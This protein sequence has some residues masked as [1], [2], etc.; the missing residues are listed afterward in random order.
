M[1]RTQDIEFLFQNNGPT[2][3]V[4]LDP[5]QFSQTRMAYWNNIVFLSYV[6][7][8]ANIHRLMYHTIYKR[9]RNDDV[10]ATAMFV[11]ADTNDLLYGDAGGVIHQDRVGSYDEENVAGTV[12]PTAIAL[13]MQTAYMDQG[14]PKN[15]KNYNELTL[16]T[17]TNGQT[18]TATLIF[19]DGQIT[20]PVGTFSTASRQKV[21]LNLLSGIGQQA[22]RV[23]LQVTGAVLSQA[24]LYQ[25]D[26]RGVILAE[27]RQS[28]DTYW[29]KFGNDES[30]IAKDLYVEYTSTTALTGNFY[31][32]QFTAPQ[33]TF[34]LPASSRIST[35]VRLPAIKFRLL[36]LV[37]TASADFQ[38]WGGSKILV[39]P[40]CA[41]KG[42]ASMDLVP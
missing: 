36:R 11:E 7:T 30:K 38:V 28:M 20:V 8:D 25:A 6:G 35:R 42:Y 26:L 34:T 2:P 17:N 9:W 13:N 40:V 1:Y 23:S 18:L 10:P 22:Y 4:E 19:N 41:T 5:T 32:D 24:V 16:D 15:Q 29:L 33:F 31:Y 14:K 12:T 3:I 39:K 27:T 21:N 37:V